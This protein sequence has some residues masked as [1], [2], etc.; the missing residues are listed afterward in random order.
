MTRIISEEEMQDIKI[1]NAEPGDYKDI[2]DLLRDVNLP[3]EGIEDNIH[4]FIVMYLNGRLIGTV[5]LEVYREKCVLRSLAV[6]KEYQNNGFGNI[7][8][9]EIMKKTAKLEIKQVY[10]LTFSAEQYFK[11]RGFYLISRDEVE[12]EIRS[13]GEFQYQVCNSAV[14]MTKMTG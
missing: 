9:S 14:C 5:G 12:E 3:S 10:L 6:S 13:Q 11:K 7:L 1:R 2:S 8:Y 4:N